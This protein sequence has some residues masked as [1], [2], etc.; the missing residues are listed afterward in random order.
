M[1]HKKLILTH[2]FL[3]QLPYFWV[4]IPHE[5][6]GVNRKG[7]RD[8]ELSIQVHLQHYPLRYGA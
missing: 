5:L 2:L 8:T 4:Q 7:Y 6:L 3:L 1:K